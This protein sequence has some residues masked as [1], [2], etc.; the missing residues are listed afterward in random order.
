MLKVHAHTD[1]DQQRFT[2]W[3]AEFAS[4]RDL[5]SRA[6]KLV[7]ETQA[8]ERIGRQTRAASILA[9]ITQ[10]ANPAFPPE[11]L[12][13]ITKLVIESQLPRCT[14]TSSHTLEAFAAELFATSDSTPSGV[15][16]ILQQTAAEELVKISSIRIA[17][18]FNQTS[19]LTIPLTLAGKEHHIRHLELDL[20]ARVFNDWPHTQLNRSI[21][22]M[23]SMA[24]SFVALETCVILCHFQHHVMV[25]ID[26]ISPAQN[27][28][29][30]DML[31]VRVS[32]QSPGM[33][34]LQDSLLAFI[35]AFMEQGPGKQKFIRFRHFSRKGEDAGAGPLVFVKRRPQRTL[36]RASREP[37]TFPPDADRP[38]KSQVVTLQDDGSLS[39]VT[40]SS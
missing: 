22:G 26:N 35:K 27:T 10:V 38:K 32:P 12:I 21:A 31:G 7:L 30:T 18:K 20:R 34:T 39:V 36:D 19:A 24:S 5:W 14:F 23:A 16:D 4:Q 13:L 37:L 9:R 29:G 11:L 40:K 6:F 1:E 2:R 15:R 3:E 28:I 8:D 25:D 33:S 17:A